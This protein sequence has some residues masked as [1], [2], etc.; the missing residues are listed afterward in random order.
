[1]SKTVKFEIG[2]RDLTIVYNEV[3]KGSIKRLHLDLPRPVVIIE[4]DDNR[5]LKAYVADII[6]EPKEV[7]EEPEKVQEEKPTEPV[8]KKILPDDNA[9][10]T[11]TYGKFRDL[12]VAIAMKMGSNPIDTLK[13]SAYGAKV[14]SLLFP[15]K[16]ND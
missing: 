4:L 9:E 1:M 14:A 13:F 15:A 7:K 16:E 3:C 12:C 6:P 2:D 11:I 10:I 8:E 5:T